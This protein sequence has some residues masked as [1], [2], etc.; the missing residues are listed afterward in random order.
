MCGFQVNFLP[1]IKPRYF[2]VGDQEVLSLLSSRMGGVLD[3]RNV[4]NTAVLFEGFNITI[5]HFFALFCL[6]DFINF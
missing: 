3:R 4:N 5:I 2:V 1:R 6:G